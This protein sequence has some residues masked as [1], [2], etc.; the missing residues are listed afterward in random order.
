MVLEMELGDFT[1]ESVVALMLRGKSKWDRINAFIQWVLLERKR[2]AQ[3]AVKDEEQL[4][5]AR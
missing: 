3:R 5:G 4:E 1:P 2:H